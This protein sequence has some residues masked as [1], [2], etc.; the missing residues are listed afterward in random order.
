MKTTRN[1]LIVMSVMLV[2]C[3]TAVVFITGTGA[4]AALLPIP[5]PLDCPHCADEFCDG[6]LRCVLTSCTETDCTDACAIDFIT[7]GW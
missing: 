3:I 4:Q 2:A 5:P 7:C 1:K 6:H